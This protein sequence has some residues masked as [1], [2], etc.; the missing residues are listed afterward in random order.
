MFHI[1][2]FWNCITYYNKVLSCHCIAPTLPACPAVAT[3]AVCT[4]YNTW[5]MQKIEEMRLRETYFKN[6]V[7]LMLRNDSGS[8]VPA[9]QAR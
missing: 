9:M 7:F 6:Y 1:G 4:F 2:Y 3:C 8:Q 5:S